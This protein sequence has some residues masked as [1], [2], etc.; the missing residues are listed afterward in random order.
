MKQVFVI[1]AIS[2]NVLKESLA[3]RQGNIGRAELII[4]FIIVIILTGEEY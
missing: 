4:S 2:F 3:V 1:K